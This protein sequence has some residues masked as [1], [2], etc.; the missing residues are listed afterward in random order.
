[1]TAIELMTLCFIVAVPREPTE[2]AQVFASSH[3]DRRNHDRARAHRK[4]VHAYRYTRPYRR[5]GSSTVNQSW[6]LNT[7]LL[8]LALSSNHDPG[9]YLP[10]NTS[11]E[12]FLSFWE[13]FLYSF[14]PHLA[15][16]HRT[17]TETLCQHPPQAPPSPV[18]FQSYV[19]QSHHSFFL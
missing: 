6:H 2:L 18:I 15:H 5:G 13:A 11:L 7:Q 8:V 9:P 3:N 17:R 12:F 4:Q 10:T 19:P 16:L 1:M 14:L